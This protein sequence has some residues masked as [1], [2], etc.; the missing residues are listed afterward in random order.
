[1]DGTK[2]RA[3]EGGPY[4]TG[5]QINVI[6]LQRK[7]LFLCYLS[8]VRFRSDLNLLSFMVHLTRRVSHVLLYLGD[9]QWKSPTEVIGYYPKRHGACD[10]LVGSLSC[11]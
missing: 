3:C 8:S 2:D 7:G 5:P 9:G 6:L 4:R 1:M 11:L 10:V